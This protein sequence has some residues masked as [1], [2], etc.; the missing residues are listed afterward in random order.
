M[1]YALLCGYPPFLSDNE[2]AMKK[3]ILKGKFEFGGKLLNMSYMFP[4]GLE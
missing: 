2:D 3:K 1:L 4:R